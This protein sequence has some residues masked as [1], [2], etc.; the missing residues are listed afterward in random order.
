[1]ENFQFNTEI[2]YT[3]FVHK[4]IEWFGIVIGISVNMN[5]NRRCNSP[6]FRLHGMI[7]TKRFSGNYYIGEQKRRTSFNFDAIIEC[8]LTCIVCVKIQCY[9]TQLYISIY[10]TTVYLEINIDQK[11][12]KTTKARGMG[13]VKKKEEENQNFQGGTTLDKPLTE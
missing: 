5:G 11:K 10:K 2:R 7:I 3:H 4:N 12:Q 6:N 9:T 1:M 13:H 8:Q